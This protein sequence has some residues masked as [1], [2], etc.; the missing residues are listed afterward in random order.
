MALLLR[1][2]TKDG[3]ERLQAPAGCTLSSLRQLIEQKFGVPV[4]QQA[5][6]RAEQSG[7]VAR[8]GAPLTPAEDA[9]ALSGLGL[10]NGDMLFLDYSMERENQAQYV[11]KDPFS[12]LV[13]EGELR[14]QGKSQWTLSNFLDYRSSK[15]FVLGAPPEPHTKYVQIDAA[16]TQK[17]M[18]FM[19]LTNFGSK[20]V[21]WLYGRW[22][23]DEASGEAGV[24][25]H[26][27]YEPA[28]DCTADTITLQDDAAADA[29]VERV[30]SMLGLTR[31]GVAIAHPAREYV[32]SVDELILAS[33]AQAAAM[34]ADPENGKHF[35]T[36]KARPVLETET[37]IDGSATVEAYQVTDQCVELVAREAFSQSKTDP[38]V[39]K[40]AKDCTFIVEKKEQ[41]KA[42][43][44]HFVARVFNIGKPF[45]SFLS[46]GFPVEN[47]PTELQDAGAFAGYLRQRKHKEPFLA[48][49]SDLHFLLFLAN[50]LDINTDLPVLCAKV[51]EGHADEAE[52]EG[53]KMM[54][55]CYAGLD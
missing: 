38:R 28:Q 46:C 45:A 39:A 42:T 8:K 1:V 50:F 22:V 27:I 49:C 14:Q 54:V 40:T 51:T 35:I 34:Q 26:A 32:F 36:M 6:A 33:Q 24:Q 4:G 47:R 37:Q 7:P 18:S 11:E 53:F 16:A 5:L 31:V 3:T 30:A 13:K 44:E 55:Y 21:G 43:V 52:L 41:R 2:R 19:M 17:L 29:K 23:T 20:R 15:E 25:V 12:T 48:T 10:A 9:Q